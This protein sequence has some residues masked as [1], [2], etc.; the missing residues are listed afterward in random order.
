VHE[1]DERMS[2]AQATQLITDA[3]QSGGRRRTRKGDVDRIAATLI[4]ERWL[5][6]HAAE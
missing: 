2:S 1:A 6:D 3:R 4:L 5:A